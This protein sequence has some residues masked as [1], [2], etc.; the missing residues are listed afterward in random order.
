MPLVSTT[1]KPDTHGLGFD[2]ADGF[3]A[4]DSDALFAA[5]R[6]RKQQ[7]QQKSSHK[8]IGLS[9]FEED[10]EIDVYDTDA[11]DAPRSTFGSLKTSA[12]APQVTFKKPQSVKTK[13][14]SSFAVCAD[15]RP[16][17][18]G[19][20][21][22]KVPLTS[23]TLYFPPPPA[24]PGLTLQDLR[25]IHVPDEAA[26]AASAATAAA[27]TSTAPSHVPSHNERAAMLG[28]ER[29]V[30]DMLKPADRER[31]LA[32]KG[33]LGAKFAPAAPAA[34]AVPPL[35]PAAARSALQGFM[36]FSDNPAKQAR[37][38]AYL[39]ASAAGTF[40]PSA[41]GDEAELGE[42]YKSA[43]IFRP[44]SSLMASRF[45]PASTGAAAA[46]VDE[47]PKPMTREAAEAAARPVRT[48][49]LWAPSRLLCKR[50]NIEPP[51]SSVP[52]A[53]AQKAAGIYSATASAGQVAAALAAAP[54][55][56]STTA[57][58]EE[59]ALASAQL[60]SGAVD[61]GTNDVFFLG[62]E[63]PSIDIFKAIFEADDTVLPPPEESTD[64]QK[65][66]FFDSAGAFD[67]GSI[68]TDKGEPS[69]LGGQQGGQQE[70][71]MLP[72]EA[73]FVA[74]LIKTATE[75]PPMTAS[76]ASSAA[77]ARPP[78]DSDDSS[79]DDDSSSGE[80]DGE[81][82][83]PA[84]KPAE[85]VNLDGLLFVEKPEK[86]KDKKTRRSA[87]EKERRRE[88]KRKRKEKKERREKKRAKKAA[89][90]GDK[91]KESRH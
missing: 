37:Y 67:F 79:S 48:E 57:A 8:S 42:F 49:L 52:H 84:A 21:L 40:S 10:D 29:S 47:T 91:R 11:F 70:F 43:N 69:A 44:L 30:L 74:R 85:T 14:A 81:D 77:A 73:D 51:S 55:A 13:A 3:M 25:H 34:P 64:E 4:D 63:K 33:G 28:E 53:A 5:A 32:I 6:V 83:K 66:D 88:K 82:E 38:A 89:K 68:D 60:P 71:Q 80:S 62:N 45:T 2:A 31:L 7:Q 87:E 76:A 61:G 65:S 56:A 16:P 9:V 22:S 23:G 50:M 58:T 12:A 36:P 39:T 26:A 75:A 59:E 19:F 54:K 1:P 24:P 72:E 90:E 46:K 17:L 20:S 18:P 35:D 86:H 41:A 27:S 15:G 78:A